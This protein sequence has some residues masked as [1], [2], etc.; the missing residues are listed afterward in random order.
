MFFQD[1]KKLKLKGSE[2]KPIFMLI[3]P[4]CFKM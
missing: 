4:A 1:T 2:K 3:A